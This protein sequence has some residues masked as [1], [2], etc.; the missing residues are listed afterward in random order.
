LP[1]ISRFAFLLA[2]FAS[3][4]FF[5]G[6]AFAFGSKAP[7]NSWDPIL[8]STSDGSLSFGVAIDG[9]EP[10]TRNPD[11]AFIPASNTK[12][13][14]T[15]AAFTVLGVDRQFET[16]MQ[17]H[18][19][20]GTPG[21]IT[22]LTL[23]GSGDPSW[24]IAE[25]GE[26]AR[27]RIDAFVKELKARGVSE[28]LGQV[29]LISNDPRWDA[30]SYPQGWNVASASVTCDGALAQAFNLR[31]NCAVFKVSSPAGGRWQGQWDDADIPIPVSLNIREGSQTALQVRAAFSGSEISTEMSSEMFGIAS[32]FVV[33]GTWANGAW[34]QAFALP[35]NDVS[36][37]VKNLLIRSLAENGIRYNPASSS[38]S[39]PE[40]QSFVSRSPTLGEILRPFLKK[41]IN[42][43]GDALSKIMG[44]EGGL[45]NNDLLAAGTQ[46]VV[47]TLPSNV[48]PGV[49]FTDGSGMS[50]QNR[51]TPSAMIALLRYFTTR[52]DFHYLWDALPIAG[53]DGTLINRMKGTAAENLL[54]A[55]TGTLSGAYNLSGYVPR[56]DA[57][58]EIVEYIPF[59]VLTSTSS[60]DETLARQTEDQIGAKLASLITNGN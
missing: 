28:V 27:T 38:S 53:V 7:S 6:S 41:S 35:I 50:H 40:L 11:Q 13:F 58:G 18:L 31:A 15:A 26:N 10:Y 21:A 36:G 34:P 45:S 49:S 29:H 43:V 22:G 19:A 14:T 33:S 24:G 16:D 12:L 2:V 17:W 25:L 1:R 52:S 9:P 55:K 23:V 59:S 20:P 42:L 3:L 56:L 46:T 48:S 5:Q 4:S 47:Q 60:T 57:G 37:W 30:L 51:I 44:K 39:D 54:R 8:D 32:G